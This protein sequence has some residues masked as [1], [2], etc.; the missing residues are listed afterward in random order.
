MTWPRSIY[1]FLTQKWCVLYLL[2][3]SSKPVIKKK[4]KTLFH[5]SIIHEKAN[6]ATHRL[7]LA[8]YARIAM[9]TTMNITK[10]NNVPER[11]EKRLRENERKNHFAKVRKHVL[12]RLFGFDY[13]CLRW[14]T[15]RE[16]FKSRVIHLIWIANFGLIVYI[17]CCRFVRKTNKKIC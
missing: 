1:D 10:V 14:G 13:S 17:Q 7:F 8:A 15:Y 9:I 11:L 2:D 16:W 4:Q 5:F 6:T 12:V 3:L